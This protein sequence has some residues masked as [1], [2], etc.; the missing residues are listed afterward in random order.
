[1]DS[2]FESE[3]ECAGFKWKVLINHMGY[4]C[5]YVCIPV[6]HPWHGRRT[7]D[8]DASVHGGLTFAKPVEKHKHLETGYWIGFDCAHGGDN[9]D[10]K[11]MTPEIEFGHEMAKQFVKE[12][13][14]KVNKGMGDRFQQ[15]IDKGGKVRSRMYVE[16]NCKNLCGQAREAVHEKDES[17]K[18]G[19]K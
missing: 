5:G 18:T 2:K 9:P 1:M 6:G 16:M 14:N 4:R 17:R 7:E 10:P 19:E 13:L 15:H 8:I 11:H 12:V 3:G